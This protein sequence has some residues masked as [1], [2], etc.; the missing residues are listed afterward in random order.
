MNLDYDSFDH[1]TRIDDGTTRVD[2]VLSPDGRV[3]RR[4]VSSPPGVT[5]TEDRWYGYMDG[6]DS[7]AWS[8][9]TTGGV[10][11]TFLPG[12]IVTGTT[13]SYEV[14]DTKG[15]IV[16]TTTQAG[17]WT[18]GSYP[19]EYGNV[20][21]VPATRLD[22]L[23]SQERFVD[24]PGLDVIRMGVRAYDPHLGRFLSQDPVVGGSANDYDYVN[25]D[26]ING[27][28]LGGTCGVWGAP[29]R[30][31]GRGHRGE[32]G[33]LG[34]FFSKQYRHRTVSANGCLIVCFS[35]RFQGG[36]FAISG[37]CC[38][39]GAAPLSASTG[40][41]AKRASA[42]DRCSVFVSG[43]AAVGAYGSAGLRSTRGGGHDADFG[44]WEI[45]MTGGGFS[46]GFGA[47]C[48]LVS[49]SLPWK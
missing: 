18:V 42:R 24:H 20:A 3:L 21:S 49:G 29:W 43:S 9:A 6:S 8:Q 28:D 38:V 30:K 44:D 27:T 14:A 7:P 19:D 5:V 4:T 25:A 41:A 36:R 45:G 10:V 33:F 12:V 11:T 17:A 37:A 23:G 26:P 46:I 40:S 22:W 39:V 47:S 2:S 1:T 31:C 16:G 34:G 32:R 48:D 15:T 35:A 13:P